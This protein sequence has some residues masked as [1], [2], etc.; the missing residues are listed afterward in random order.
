MGSSLQKMSGHVAVYPKI[1]RASMHE[2]SELLRLEG[3]HDA[4]KT[5]SLR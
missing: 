2:H 3:M 4:K 1:E 5:G